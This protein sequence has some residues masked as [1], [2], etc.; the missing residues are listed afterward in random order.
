MKG[1]AKRLAGAYWRLVANSSKREGGV[2]E[3]KSDKGD[4]STRTTNEAKRRTSTAYAS[5]STV[6]RTKKRET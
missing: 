2:H 4:E 5:P 6:V 3:E 1:T